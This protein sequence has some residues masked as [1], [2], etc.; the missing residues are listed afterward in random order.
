MRWFTQAL[1]GSRRRIFQHET[2]F[3][4]YRNDVR[5]R[6]RLVRERSPNAMSEKMHAEVEELLTGERD[7]DDVFLAEKLVVT[8]APAETVQALLS[9]YLEKYKFEQIGLPLDWQFADHDYDAAKKKEALLFL[10]NVYQTEIV[11]RHVISRYK[12]Q[13]AHLVSACFVG[14][15]G[16]P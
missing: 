2:L 5:A 10:I 6:Y 13:R 1:S 14:V 11:K 12:V 7:W 16:R 9:V 4:A 8:A 15:A 3:V